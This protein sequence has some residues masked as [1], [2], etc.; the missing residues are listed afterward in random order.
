MP[1]SLL[2]E[3]EVTVTVVVG[4]VA[5][6]A[7]RT[8]MIPMTEDEMILRMGRRIIFFIVIAGVVVLIIAYVLFSGGSGKTY[9]ALVN[10]NPAFQSAEKARVNGDHQAAV[11]QYQEALNMSNDAFS[12]GQIE[13]RMAI[14][15]GYLGKY[16]EAIKVFKEIH[17]NRAYPPRLRAYAVADMADLYRATKSPE[18]T[19]QIFSEEPFKG[20]YDP[21]DVLLSYRKLY[22]YAAGIYSI[23]S[24][25]LYSAIWYSD[26]ISFMDRGKEPDKITAYS[27]AVKSKVALADQDIATIENAASD[28]LKADLPL[29]YLLR[30]QIIGNLELS[31]DPSLGNMEDAFAK[32]FQADAL[33]GYPGSDSHLRYHY[34]RFLW[35]KYGES[36]KN[37]IQQMLE[38]LINDPIYRNS[39]I[40]KYL[41]SLRD[42]PAPKKSLYRLA[43]LYPEFMDYLISLGWQKSDFTVIE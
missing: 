12:Q 38:P 33:Y 9:M 20:F 42:S 35:K 15:N 43:N 16:T 25:E 6:A 23:A 22:D 17:A 28:N 19:R 39:P 21:S 41:T 8:A 14:S 11:D 34:A 26:Q 4:G 2:K 18:I 30:A 31:G 5:A 7:D 36:K 1:M 3:S 29:F 24:A 27:M 10:S 37:E 32:S 40:E 13:L